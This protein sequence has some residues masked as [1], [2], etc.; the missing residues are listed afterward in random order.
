MLMQG[1]LVIIERIAPVCSLFGRQQL[2][3]GSSYPSI[4]ILEYQ[5][6]NELIFYNIIFRQL[7]FPLLRRIEKAPL[8]V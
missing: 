4:V 2:E 3:L 6:G 5:S 7:V 1:G 8:C